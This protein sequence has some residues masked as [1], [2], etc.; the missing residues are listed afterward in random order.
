[1]NVCR[2]PGRYD[3]YSSSDIIILKINA[4]QLPEAV[5]NQIRPPPFQFGLIEVTAQTINFCHSAFES[6][7]NLAES[8]SS[9]LVE[10][11]V[12][13]SHYIEPSP[14]T[15]GVFFSRSAS[16][17]TLDTRRTRSLSLRTDF[18]VTNFASVV[19]DIPTLRAISL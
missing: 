14:F 10:P 8:K 7:S 5:E 11:L 4:L 13:G 3:L 18:P 6:N 9:S 15:L 16:T 2:P 19:R 12:L 17:T 1:M